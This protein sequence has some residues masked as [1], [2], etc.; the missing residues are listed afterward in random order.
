MKSPL[1]GK[2]T[3]LRGSFSKAVGAKK[4]V[5]GKS[6]IAG[7]SA[8]KTSVRKGAAGKVKKFCERGLNI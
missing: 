2:A 3:T 4:V 8:T 1:A 6:T 5:A 7:V